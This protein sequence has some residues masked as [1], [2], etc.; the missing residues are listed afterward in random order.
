MNPLSPDQLNAMTG[1]GNT[2]PTQ[3]TN[4]S[5]QPDWLN[6][7][8]NSGLQPN[9]SAAVLGHSTNLLA[10]QIQQTGTSGNPIK[11][12][13]LGLGNSTLSPLLRV[14]GAVE[15]G[16]DQTLGRGINAI[17]GHGFTPTNSGQQAF[18]TA[19]Y[20]DKSTPTTL[21]GTAGKAV[22][23]VAPFVAGAGPIGAAEAGIEGTALP[24]AAKIAAKAGTEAA[25]GGAVGLAQTGDPK[26]AALNAALFGATK[27][28]TGTIG[29]AAKAIGLPEHLYSTIFKTTSND[30]LDQLKGSGIQALSKD[31]PEMFQKLV[32]AGIIK[33]VSDGNYTVDETLAKQA[34]DKGLKGSIENM[35]NVLVKDTLQNELS[36]RTI[37]QNYDKPIAIAGADKLASLF[38]EVA[39]DYQN[40]G[41]GEIAQKALGYAQELENPSLKSGIASGAG[42]VNAEDALGMRRFLDGMRARS[43]YNPQVKLSTTGENFK[44]WSDKVRGAV[45]AIP[46]MQSVMKDYSFNIDALSALAKTAAQKGNTQLVNMLDILIFEG[47]LTGG[48]PGLGASMSLGRKGIQTAAGATGLGS[49]IQNSGSLSKL[50]AG[51][52]GA[53][54][55]LLNRGNQQP[56]SPQ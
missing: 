24:M 33:G 54:G 43:S 11:D 41:Q 32:D 37:A 46:G 50:G 22:G 31:N 2:M 49:A 18:D 30:M 56:E 25:F 52:K 45:N 42:E 55:G 23:T 6:A 19:D 48:I 38:K 53:I 26:S 34:L 29:A 9:E 40:V 7:M 12:F 1:A 21:A 44:Y 14:G 5:G 47:G 39:A 17:T 28:V 8:V 13:A 20:L 35:S 36:A 3:P 51:L 10:Q 15:T 27:G 16:L 4:T